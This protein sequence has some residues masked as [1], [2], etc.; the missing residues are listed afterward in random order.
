MYLLK[1]LLKYS[2]SGI[3]TASEIFLILMFGFL[4]DIELIIER[5]NAETL[6]SGVKRGKPGNEFRGSTIAVAKNRKHGVAKQKECAQEPIASRFL[7]TFIHPRQSRSPKS[8]CCN[9][10]YRMS[11]TERSLILLGDPSMT[12]TV[13]FPAFIS[14]K[15]SLRIRSSSVE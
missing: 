5:W 12:V 3:P 10:F 11:Y 9:P 14:K 2:W 13:R 1:S 7:R 4:M 8:V 15:L 6:M